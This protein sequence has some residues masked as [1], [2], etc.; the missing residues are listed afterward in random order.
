M[1]KRK[2]NIEFARIIASIMVISIHV[3][4]VYMRNFDNISKGYFLGSLTFSSL[5]RVCVPLF[6]MISGM[7]LLQS[8]ICAKKY[9]SKT[10]KFIFTLCVWSV[11]YFITKNGFNF[12]NIG[13]VIVNSFFNA[14]MTSRHLWYMYPLIAIYIALPFIQLLCK[15]MTKFHENLFLVLWTSISG[16]SFIY[17]PLAKLVLGNSAE[18]LYPVPIVTSTYYL[19]YFISGHILH[20]RFKEKVFNKKENT[21]CILT[22]FVST[23]IM[24]IA[25]YIVSTAKNA[26]LDSALW[27]RSA[28]VII[29]SFATFL[30]VLGNEN[31]FTN[32]KILAVSKHSF[33][34]YLIH[35]MFL[36]II[37]RHINIALINPVFAIPVI[38][39]IVFVCSVL[40]CSVLNRIPIVKKILF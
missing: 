8:E 19:G 7:F 30:L 18:I 34:V 28:L 4:N 36:N 3:A 38:T 13:K 23:V 6:F 29:A 31:R 22:Y 25:T 10:L 20:K 37:K 12:Q 26:F 35:M 27:Y 40:S 17:L 9:Y 16:L 24:I 1:A 21:I 15:N 5:A 32:T 39:I 2:I 33:G 11:I 14:N